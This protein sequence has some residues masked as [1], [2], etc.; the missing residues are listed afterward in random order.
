MHAGGQRSRGVGLVRHAGH[1]GGASDVYGDPP[2]AGDSTISP[3]SLSTYGA[4]GLQD[5]IDQATKVYP[6]GAV[7]DNIWPD[8]T[9]NSD[10]DLI[11]DETNLDNWGNPKGTG[12]CGDYMPIIYA[13]GNLDVRVGT[14]QGILIVEGDL[15]ADG[16]YDFYGIVIVKGSLNTAGTGNHFEGNVM[17][18]G[19]GN[20]STLSTASGNALVQYSLCRV[21][22]AF[23]ANMRPRPLAA[24]SWVDFTA[25][26]RG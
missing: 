17:V 3:T 1:N 14:G 19:N 6:P 23:D 4:I 7:A 12:V 10:G 13:Q 16:N 9:T 2:V 24:R 5:L 15:L 26:T 20:I 11:C 22:R 21:Q 8:S 18:M 25:N